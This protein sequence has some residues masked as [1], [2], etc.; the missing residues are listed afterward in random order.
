MPRVG[1]DDMIW[2]RLSLKTDE[3]GMVR[4]EHAV[5]GLS[6]HVQAYRPANEAA[7]ARGGPFFQ[8]ADDVVVLLPPESK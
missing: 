5:P 7:K 6:Y 3:A 8:I 4:V 2:L 1:D